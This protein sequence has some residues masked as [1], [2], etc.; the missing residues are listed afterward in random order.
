MTL[1]TNY[2]YTNHTSYKET[3]H[4]WKSADDKSADDKCCSFWIFQKF[5]FHDLKFSITCIKF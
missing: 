4:L 1:N 5:E 3:E 2:S